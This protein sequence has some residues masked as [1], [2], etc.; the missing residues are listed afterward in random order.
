[1]S[2][3]KTSRRRLGDS[4]EPWYALVIVVSVFIFVSLG[5]ISITAINSLSIVMLKLFFYALMAIPLFPFYLI[6]NFIITGIKT[7][8]YP[9]LLFKL[10]K[11]LADAGQIAVVSITAI[12]VF[13]SLG[14]VFT[15]PHLTFDGASWIGFAILLSVFGLLGAGWTF[16]EHKIKLWDKQKKFIGEL[17]LEK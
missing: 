10:F 9:Y 1:M 3:D 7:N 12:L 15:I 16:F 13:F 17:G 2:E 14:V 6:F 5:A 8:Q 11:D 4:L